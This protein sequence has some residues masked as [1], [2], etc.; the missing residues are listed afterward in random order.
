MLVVMFL[1]MKMFAHRDIL[2]FPGRRPIDFTG[3]LAFR[4]SKVNHP[5]VGGKGTKKCATCT[6]GN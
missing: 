5:Q 1:F 6:F 3:I 2:S 4:L